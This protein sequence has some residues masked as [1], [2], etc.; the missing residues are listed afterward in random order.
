M[1]NLLDLICEHRQ[2]QARLGPRGYAGAV[3][4]IVHEG[5][6]VE[7][8]ISEKIAAGEIEP[9]KLVFVRVIVDH[10]PRRFEM[11]MESP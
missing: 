8:I 10:D 2:R 11:M 9:D 1:G 7:K 3:R 6:D 5:E 4:I